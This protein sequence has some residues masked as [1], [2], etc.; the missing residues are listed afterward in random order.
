MSGLSGK[1]ALVTGA[2]SGIGRSTA[3][4]LGAGGARVGVHY[5]SDENGAQETASRIR[6]AGG[7]AFTLQGNLAES[8][9]A[10]RLWT[11]FETH[12][13]AVD[14][15]VNNAGAPSKGGIEAATEAD[16]DAVFAVNLR[17]PLFIIQGA[18]PR[19]RDGGRIINVTSVGVQVA[20]PPEI[21]YL[22]CKGG[23]NTVTRSLAWQLGARHITVNAVAPGF[24]DTPMAAP[25]LSNPR[26]RAWAK[27]LNALG[28]AGQPID[29]ANVIAFLASDE[30]R[31]ITGQV[32]DVSG[33][34][35]LGVPPLHH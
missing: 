10:Q 31:W 3:I 26:I 12:S 35:L 14:I 2:S 25:Y 7:A 4:R 30:G 18:L 29:V 33:G 22:A 13:A 17:A 11:D 32:I 20:L 19:M 23:I 6:D 8:A 15:V 28:N 24:I 5:R 9:A 1:V 27:A 21:M 34:T 16:F